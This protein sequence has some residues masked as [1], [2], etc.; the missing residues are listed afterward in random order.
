M[1]TEAKKCKPMLKKVHFIKLSKES[2]LP[3]MLIMRTKFSLGFNKSTSHGSKLNFILI[4]KEICEKIFRN[5]Y[6]LIQLW[7]WMNIMVLQI[8]TI[9]Q[10]AAVSI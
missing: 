8:G 5:S 9:M 6:F 7:P 1:H 4:N 2:F 10:N 3:R